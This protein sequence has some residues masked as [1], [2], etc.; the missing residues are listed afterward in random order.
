MKNKELNN[1]KYCI[2][3]SFVHKFYKITIK[4]S[5]GLIQKFFGINGLIFFF[6]KKLKNASFDI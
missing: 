2:F 1:E 5:V 4:I 3:L 6:I